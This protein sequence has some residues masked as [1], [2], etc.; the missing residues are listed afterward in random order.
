[1]KHTTYNDNRIRINWGIGLRKT[2]NDLFS[3]GSP[4]CD[5]ISYYQGTVKQGRIRHTERL[6]ENSY[7]EDIMQ[8]F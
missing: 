2:H 4:L 5:I 6:G 1:M 8:F 3:S 7:S